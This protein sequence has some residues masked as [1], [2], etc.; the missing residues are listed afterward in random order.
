MLIVTD[1]KMSLIRLYELLKLNK[2]PLFVNDLF[3]KK[4]KMLKSSKNWK[5][6]IVI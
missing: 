3:F 1:A 4:N 5:N 2:G 6:I